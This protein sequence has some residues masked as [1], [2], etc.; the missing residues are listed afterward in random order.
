MSDND[1]QPIPVIPGV[2]KFGHSYVVDPIMLHDMG[3]PEIAK[4]YITDQ[5]GKEAWEA[6]AKQISLVQYTSPGFSSGIMFKTEYGF[7]PDLNLFA[8]AVR[9]LIKD[10]YRDGYDAALKELEGKEK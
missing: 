2:M 8:K 10:T 9:T 5:F 3:S 7:I 6:I 4:Q 1:N